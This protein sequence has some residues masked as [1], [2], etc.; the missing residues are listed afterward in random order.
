M[1][2]TTKIVLGVVAAVVVI[3]GATM[4]FG[5]SSNSTTSN[6]T[7]QTPQQNQ[8]TG[9][10]ATAVNAGVTSPTDTSDAAL[11]KDT[12]NIDTQLSGLNADATAAIPAS[13]NQ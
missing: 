11:A 2:K 5:G 3:W 7:S 12:A 6:Q 9:E 4:L 1:S 8:A 13:D 10:T